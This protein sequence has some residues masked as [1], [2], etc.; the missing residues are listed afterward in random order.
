MQHVQGNSGSHWTL[1]SGDYLLFIA[2]TAARVIENKTKM[3]YVHTLMAILMAIAMG[4]YYTASI[5]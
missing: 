4:R 2:P 5:T 3:Y 1:P